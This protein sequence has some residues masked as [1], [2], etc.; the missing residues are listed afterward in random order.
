M[1]KKQCNAWFSET[2]RK[3]FKEV[4][5]E[6]TRPQ[7]IAISAKETIRNHPECKRYLDR[8]QKKI[9]LDDKHWIFWSSKSFRMHRN[10]PCSLRIFFSK[11]ALPSN[12]WKSALRTLFQQ[13]WGI[14]TRWP[15]SFA[16]DGTTN[17]I[18]MEIQNPKL[19]LSILTDR[20]ASFLD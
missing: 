15:N 12:K 8:P 4:G 14:A 5:K 11:K 9:V 13:K 20:V 17:Y 2:I 18:E 3:N 7:V 1:G 10:K 19:I 6:K 16:E